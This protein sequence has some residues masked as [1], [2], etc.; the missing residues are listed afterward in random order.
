MT[1]K[2]PQNGKVSVPNNSD[3]FG[4]LWYTKNINLEEEGYIKLSSRS[5]ALISEA[6]DS[7]VGIPVAFGRNGVGN[8]STTFFTATSNQAYDIV[9]GNVNLS[10]TEDTGTNN[11]S[12]SFDSSGLWF[13]NRW[14]VST[15]TKIFYKTAVNWTDSGVS[16]TSGK[17]H[18]MESFRN[19]Q[20]L[21]VGNGNTVLQYDTSYASSTTLTIPADYE[22]IGLSYSN[23][24]MAVITML[25]DTTSGQN[26]EAFLFVWDGANTS[27]SQG[28]PVGSDTIMAIVPYKSSWVILT[29]AGQL[30]YFN[31]GGFENLANFPFYYSGVTLGDP[32]NREAF[33]T[34]MSVDG[35]VILINIGD[36][37]NPYT[38]KGERIVQNNPCGIW[39]YDPDVG[40][41]HRYS[42]SISLGSMI[43]VTSGNINTTTD[44]F[45]KTAGTL[46]PTGSPIKYTSDRSNQIGGLSVGTVYFIIKITS[47]TFK[48]ATTKANADAGNWIDI[49]STGAA[50]NYFVGIDVL[51][52]GVTTSTGRTGGIGLLGIQSNTFDHI[53]FGGEYVKYNSNID[54][55]TINL[56]ISEFDNRGYFVTAKITSQEVTDNSQKVFIKY[57]PLKNQDLIVVKYKNDD[58]AGI[59]TSTSSATGGTSSRCNW[60]SS[61]TFTTTTDLSE[62]ESYINDSDGE[63]EVEIVNGAGAGQMAQISTITESSGTYTITLAEEIIGA[64]SGYICD[65]II[66]N[67]KKI[68]EITTSDTKGWMEFPINK[69]SKYI[70]LKVE[71]RGSNTTVEELQLVNVNQQLAK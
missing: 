60:T 4:N 44:I 69:S 53:I 9:V 67:W 50:N 61:T 62:V 3:L 14:H 34:S 31:G 5:I 64:A 58:V 33:G 13:I 6:D 59:P 8:N 35:D 70:K 51:D 42:P 45:T 26:Q 46:P 43:T 30:K 66:D 11:P 39:C 41:Y 20:T 36:D 48:L 56:T 22:V 71:L 37:F 25:S 1:V 52:F 32:Q 12:C 18:P 57:R 27:A 19:R 63:C 68:G 21:C 24:K 65:T 49:T 55:A 47:T 7:N 40:L 23:N 28:F 15:N 54:Y 2:I 38:Q 17:A 16:L 10:T 29:R